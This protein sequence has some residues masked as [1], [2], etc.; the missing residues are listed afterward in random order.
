MLVVKFHFGKNTLTAVD[1]FNDLIASLFG[2]EHMLLLRILTDRGS[3]HC[4]NRKHYDYKLFF[5]V[6]EPDNTRT[7][8]M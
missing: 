3:E 6:E 8:V 2:A 4:D 1:L 5:S 7:K